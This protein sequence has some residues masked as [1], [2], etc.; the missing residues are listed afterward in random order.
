[1]TQEKMSEFIIMLLIEEA[2]SRNEEYLEYV[3]EHYNIKEF[4]TRYRI[5]L[6]TFLNRYALNKPEK[7]E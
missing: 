1:M 2:C 7:S 5:L 3:R 6:D 4:N